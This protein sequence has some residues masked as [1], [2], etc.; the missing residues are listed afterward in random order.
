MTVDEMI[1]AT[2]DWQ[3]DG[4][5]PPLFDA[6]ETLAL[7]AEIERLRRAEGRLGPV[8]QPEPETWE[9]T[10]RLRWDRHGDLQQLWRSSLGREEWRDVE[11][12]ERGM[13]K[14]PPPRK[15]PICEDC[16]IY[17]SDPPSK[18]CPGCQAYKDHTR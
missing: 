6:D 13:N 5:F 12:G 3:R 16:G 4:G 8:P 9:P 7:V 15:P 18:L 17:P 10:M 2:R 14:A 11:D 1:A